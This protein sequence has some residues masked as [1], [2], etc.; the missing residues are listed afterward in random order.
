MRYTAD[1]VLTE[2]KVYN[3]ECVR[4]VMVVSDDTLSVNHL[5]PPDPLR[6]EGRTYA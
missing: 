4:L 1:S 2:T 6:R 5:L 3:A